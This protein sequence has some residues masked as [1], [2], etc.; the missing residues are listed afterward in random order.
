MYYLKYGYVLV[1]D[2]TNFQTIRLNVLFEILQFLRKYV[3]WLLMH[4]L[5]VVTFQGIVFF[6]CSAHNVF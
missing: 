6:K 1:Y 4:V 5:D 2:M 3:R